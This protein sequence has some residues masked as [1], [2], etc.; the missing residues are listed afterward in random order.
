MKESTNYPYSDKLLVSA[1]LLGEPVR[2]DGNSKSVLSEEHKAWLDSLKSEKKLVV[3][4]PEVAGGLPTPR[5]AAEIQDDGRVINIHQQE[6][7]AEF[8]AGANQALRLCLE[9][10]IGVALLKARSPSC[11]NTI[12]HDGS[13]SK[14]YIQGQGVTA[15]LLMEHGIEV[16]SELQIEVLIEQFKR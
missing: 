16:F 4:C 7:T 12:I 2:Y 13:F 3:V 9:H 15:K 1:C 6:V 14:R 5:P 11:G 10:N 8:N